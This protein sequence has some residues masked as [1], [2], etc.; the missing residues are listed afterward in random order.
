[1]LT[2][3]DQANAV[4]EDMRGHT[5]VLFTQGTGIV[6]EKSSKQKM[7]TRTSTEYVNMLELANICQKTFISKY[8][9]NVLC[10]DNESWS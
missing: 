7:N 9:W 2:M 3:V 1:M 8:L 4:H 6:D 10:K 5:E